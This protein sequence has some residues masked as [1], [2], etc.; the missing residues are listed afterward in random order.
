MKEVDAVFIGARCDL[1][2]VNGGI[3]LLEAGE[4]RLLREAPCDHKQ[5][6][7]DACAQGREAV[8]NIP[9]DR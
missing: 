9:A 3:R 4:L 1:H 7:V 6:D 5:E 2:A 8:Q